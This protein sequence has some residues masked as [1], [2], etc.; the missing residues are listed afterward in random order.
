MGGNRTFQEY[1][2]EHSANYFR[3]PGWAEFQIEGAEI[4]PPLATQRRQFNE[5]STLKELVSEYGDENGEFLFEQFNAFRKHHTGLTYISL[6]VASD[7]ASRSRAQAEA[8]KEGWQFE[9]V[10]GTL[11]MLERLANGEWNEGDVLLVP[12]G[13]T[14]HASMDDSVLSAE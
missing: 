14:I 5:R 11:R 12:P 2:Q 10:K 4:E 8:A 7:Q 1:F 13:A 6:P 3:T 9:E